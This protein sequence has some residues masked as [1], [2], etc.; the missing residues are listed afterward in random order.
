MLLPLLCF[1]CVK[2]YFPSEYDCLR[3]FVLYKAPAADMFLLR[4]YF[5]QI[6]FFEKQDLLQCC[7]NRK[8]LRRIFRYIVYDCFL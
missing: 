8:R 6:H 3:N 5:A 4:L 7:F 1:F 2:R